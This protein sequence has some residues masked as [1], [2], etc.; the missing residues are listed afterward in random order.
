MLGLDGVSQRHSCF[1]FP[2][3]FCHLFIP[4]RLNSKKKQKKFTHKNQKQTKII[5]FFV[6]STLLLLL[7]I[8][9]LVNGHGYMSEPPSRNWYTHTDGLDWGTSPGVPSKEYCP[10]CLN[11]NK[12]VCGFSESN[13]D[14]DVWVDSLGQ[15]MPWTTQRT[16]SRGETITVLSTLSAHHAGHME[17]RG[18]PDGRASTQ[19]CF[20]SHVFEFVEDVAFGMPKDPNHPERGYYWGGPGKG[21]TSFAM[22]FKIPDSLVGD[23]VVIQWLYVTA[24]SC[25]PE[26]YAS[27]FNGANSLGT[28]VDSSF[29]TSG[30]SPCDGYGADTMPLASGETSGRFGEQ[31]VNCAEVAILDGPPS[32]P[33]TSAP[34]IKTTKAPTKSPTKAPTKSPTKSPTKAPVTTG[35][36]FP[37]KSPTMAPTPRPTTKAPTKAPTT[38]TGPSGSFCCS[39]NYKDCDVTGWCA[40]SQSRCEGSCGASWIEVGSC[41]GIPLWGDCT[42]DTNGCCAPATCQGDQWYKQC[43]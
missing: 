35:T 10:H 43:K 22:T 1:P 32:A 26:G 5:M 24:N 2:F 6:P 38:P 23:K 11:R 18:C 40:Q 19:E 16:Y 36:S 21:G 15:E 39:N 12:G 8:P 20:D 34:T 17:L 37:T 13:I 3:V 25:T 9:D 14:F 28:V 7:A 41:T 30:L 33:V 31:F 4:A 42:N 29:W 27:Y